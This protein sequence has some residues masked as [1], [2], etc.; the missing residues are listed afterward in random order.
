QYGHI[1]ECASYPSDYSSV[2]FKLRPEAKFHDGKPITPE[3][4]IFSFEQFKKVNPFYA[5]YYK[6]VDKAEKTGDH[7]VTFTFNVKGNRELPMMVGKR[8]F[9]PKHA[10]EGKDT[11]GKQPDLAEP[12]VEPPL[13]DGPYKIKSVDTGRK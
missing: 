13:G 5:F 1:A 8:A 12:T 2:T 6:N 10:W 3:D 11:S 4:V 9:V 7:E